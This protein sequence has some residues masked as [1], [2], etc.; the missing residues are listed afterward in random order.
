M[1]PLCCTVQ[2]IITHSTLTTYWYITEEE[3]DMMVRTSRKWE[4]ILVSTKCPETQ[5][6]HLQFSLCTFIDNNINVTF[7]KRNSHWKLI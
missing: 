1:T 3:Q 2:E 4:Q 6:S 5:V 7:K